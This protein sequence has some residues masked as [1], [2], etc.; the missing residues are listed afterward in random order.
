MTPATQDSP[1]ALFRHVGPSVDEWEEYLRNMADDMDKQHQ[2]GI[3]DI[4]SRTKSSE[5]NI[6]LQVS[7]LF[8]K[9]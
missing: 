3:I 4:S 5:E 2:T 8:K 7:C 9:T 1:P 6:F